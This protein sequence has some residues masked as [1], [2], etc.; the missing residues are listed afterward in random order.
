MVKFP[1]RTSKP[2][3]MSFIE[4]D[5]MARWWYEAVACED[6]GSL[7]LIVGVFDLPRSHALS[8]SSAQIRSNSRLTPVE[9]RS[10]TAR[11]N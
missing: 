4:D 9:L 6:C 11:K 8:L 1:K 3:Q 7:L 5:L 2:F 10:A